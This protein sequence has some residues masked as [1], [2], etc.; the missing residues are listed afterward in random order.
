MKQLEIEP[1]FLKLY[2]LIPKD[3]KRQ[4]VTILGYKTCSGFISKYKITDKE[5]ELLQKFVSPYVDSNTI[6]NYVPFDKEQVLKHYNALTKLISTAA[7][8]HNKA[9][10]KDRLIDYQLDLSRQLMRLETY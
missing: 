8:Q 2:H 9:H 6:L 5:M 1:E 4:L 10:E 3:K 7:F